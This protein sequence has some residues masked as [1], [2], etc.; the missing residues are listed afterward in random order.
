MVTNND[1]SIIVLGI[2]LI[3]TGDEISMVTWGEIPK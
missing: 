2:D 3:A 1:E